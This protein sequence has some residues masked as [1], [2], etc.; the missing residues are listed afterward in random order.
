[1]TFAN[2]INSS[3]VHFQS[4]SGTL[5]VADRLRV[6]TTGSTFNLGMTLAAG[7]FTVTGADGTALSATNPAYVILQDRSSP[8][9]NRIFT[10]TAN[11]TFI[12]DAGASTIIGNLFGL[13]TGIAAA[14]DMPFFLYAVSN[15]AEDTILFAI[16]RIPHRTVAPAAGTF[17]KTGSAVASTQGSFFALGDPTI[18]DYDS[19]PCICIGSFR[20]QMSAADDWTVQTLASNDGVGRFNESTEFSVPRGQFGVTASKYFLDNGGTAPDDADG[21]YIY[22][23]AKNGFCQGMLQFPIIDTDGVGSVATRAVIPYT[24][25][26]ARQGLFGI[27]VLGGTTAYV[28]GQLSGNLTLTMSQVNPGSSTGLDNVQFDLGDLIRFSWVLT[29]AIA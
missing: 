28:E 9:L 15:D 17:G 10:V 25:A 18:A 14:V 7:T 3:N 5:E 1:M 23:I 22:T 2:A 16:S 4:N 13:T 12:D 21:T 6:S 11:Q 26:S 20:M 19:N 27:A 8:G 24:V 29:P